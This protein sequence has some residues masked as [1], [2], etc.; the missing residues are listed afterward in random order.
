MREKFF[1]LFTLAVVILCGIGVGFGIRFG[2]N[3]PIPEAPGE[4]SDSIV[5]DKDSNGAG[6]NDNLNEDGNG[7]STNDGEEDTDNSVDNNNDKNPSKPDVT[8][9][10]ETEKPTE[11][12]TPDEKPEVPSEPS[13]PTTPTEPETPELDFSKFYI[14]IDNE[15]IS[16]KEFL[17][18]NTF[19]ENPFK[20]TYV[21]DEMNVTYTLT[22]NMEEIEM[23]GYD[24]EMMKEFINQAL[25]N[26][27][28]TEN[29]EHYSSTYD[30]NDDTFELVISYVIAG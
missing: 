27:I 5:A 17:C 29:G 12:E 6:D 4:P 9:P 3:K 23:F 16:L 26:N 22:F 13:E 20:S 2:L 19:I 14:E 10:D 21:K 7:S 11:P 25:L 30:F 15:I 28:I 24:F 18:A 1:A 8:I